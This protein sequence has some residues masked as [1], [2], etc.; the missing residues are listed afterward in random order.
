MANEKFKVKFGLAVGDT[1][2][3]VDGTTGNIYTIGDAEI[4]SNL[5]V[6]GSATLGNT[7]GDVVYINGT[8]TVFNGLTIGSSSGDTVTVN[9]QVTD[10]IAFTDNST[11]TNRGIS[12]TVGT[13]DY[14]K[15]GGGA[16]GSNLGY[17][18]IATGDDGN[19][20]IYARQYSSGSIN[21]QVTLLDASGNTVLAGDLT[22]GGNGYIYSPT[23]LALDLTGANVRTPGDLT[24]D[25]GD[26]IGSRPLQI[27]TTDTFATT[28]SSI[29]GTT[30]TIGTLTSGT[31]SVG[32]TVT[33][34]TTANGT[35]ITAN[36][37][38]TG[39]GST[40][41]VSISQTVASSAITGAGNITLAP[42][43]AGSVAV[44]LTNGGNL[45][46]NRNY[47][48]GSIRN[49]TT[50]GIGDIWALNSTGTVTPF[51]GV[52][53]DNSADTT[54]GPGTLMR[55]YSGGAVAGSNLR[56]RVIFEKARGTAAAPT[57]LQSGDFLGSVDATGYTSTGWL[58]DNIAAVAPAFFGFAAAENWV[59]NTNL[60]TNFSLSLAPTATTV[61][62]AANLV[63]VLS[64]TPQTSTYRADTHAFTGGKSGTYSLMELTGVRALCTVPVKFPAFL[65]TAVNG[66]LATTGA[67]S[68]AGTAT[69]TFGA[70]ASAPFTVGSQVV[71]AGI[72]PTGFNGTQTVTA[73]TTS[74][75]S[76]TNSTTGPQTVAGTVKVSGSIGWQ[77]AISDSAQGSNPN[78]MMAFWD[79]TNNRFSYI[80]DNSAV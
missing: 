25:G 5:Q 21:K 2:A 35:V 64:I 40:W 28:G 48:S 14:W 9:S 11:T 59:S 7:V 63:N 66:T 12:G 29:S 80:H 47:V 45:T 1:A 4:N 69:I 68:T 15:Y 27:S 76:Y 30:L 13:N 75:V 39:S 20:P 65:A 79:T 44:N 43:T 72:T 23:D 3:T 17:A 19:E 67:S 36:I 78:G 71:V 53:L 70:L 31:I 58:N 61:T 26:L 49:T 56:G 32:M 51:R 57:A 8:A 52:S 54:K 34:G 50:A 10:N 24:I 41:T 22:V 18:E 60:G 33:G 42:V 55:S 62:G 46:N 73:C 74:S 37:S 77:I 6:N 38:G 16:T